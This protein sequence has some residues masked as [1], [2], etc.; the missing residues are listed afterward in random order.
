ME[1]VSVGVGDG[2]NIVQS[3]ELI[4]GLGIRHHSAVCHRQQGKGEVRPGINSIKEDQQLGRKKQ[5]QNR[6][7][8]CKCLKL[9]PITK[10]FTDAKV[11]I[12]FI[13]KRAVSSPKG[14]G[15]SS[16]RAV[17][18]VSSNPDPYSSHQSHATNISV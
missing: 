4:L 13:G 12:H 1:L 7:V 5:L 14:N 9:S 2:A 3:V 10:F 11:A 15:S 17:K 8:F 16:S 6:E 18:R